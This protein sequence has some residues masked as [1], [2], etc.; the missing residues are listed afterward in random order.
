MTVEDEKRDAQIEALISI[1]GS[2]LTVF[3]IK[4][5]A[6]DLWPETMR[7]GTPDE[8]RTVTAEL[9]DV[10]PAA[11]LRDLHPTR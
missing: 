9:A 10:L 7:K 6:A 8:I 4:A 3:D 1:V 11:L 2:L 5:D